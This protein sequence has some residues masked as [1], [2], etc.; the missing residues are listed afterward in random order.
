MDW[1]IK[2]LKFN[3]I[4]SWNIKLNKKSFSWDL[5]EIEGADR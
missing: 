3:R 1:A 5:K 2:D 4:N